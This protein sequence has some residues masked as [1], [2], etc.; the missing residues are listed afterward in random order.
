LDGFPLGSR[1]SKSDTGLPLPEQK[2]IE[3]LN[4]KATSKL[5][6]IVRRAG[7]SGYQGYDEAEI[8]AAKELLNRDSSN[9]IR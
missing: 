4:Q 3:L 9:I 6:D 8:I 5:S 1:Q 2:T 7:D